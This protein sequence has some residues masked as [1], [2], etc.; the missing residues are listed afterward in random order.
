M[1]TTSFTKIS[2]VM[3]ISV[4]TATA[5]FACMLPRPASASPPTPREVARHVHNRVSGLF[6]K[7][8]RTLEGAPSE[9]RDLG[10]EREYERER[11]ERER[12]YEEEYL[13][14][15]GYNG[16]RSPRKETGVRNPRHYDRDEYVAPPPPV[17]NSS[18]RGP[19]G[20]RDGQQN[21]GRD[22]TRRVSPDTGGPDVSLKNRVDGR[23]ST[24][25][26]SRSANSSPEKAGSNATGNRSSNKDDSSVTGRSKSDGTV[27]NN[28][29]EKKAQY[30][31]PVPNKN[32]FVYPPGSKQTSEN[33]LD[34]RGLE[35]GQKARDPRTGDV[36]LVP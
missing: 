11:Y 32:G 20:Y 24:A 18:R 7:I 36:F 23:E 28:I 3:G 12:A 35:P 9:R 27:S 19:E 10:R 31:T 2:R 25:P 30:A 29:G 8:A 5:I 34:V 16:E 33:M 15:E 22:E 26:V 6:F 13:Y 4:C 1:N 21:Q 17:S 14:E